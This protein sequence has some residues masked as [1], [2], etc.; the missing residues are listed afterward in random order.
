MTAG[1]PWQS[2]PRGFLRHLFDAALTAADPARAMARHP[3]PPPEGRM[4]VIGAGKAAAA[5]AQMVEDRWPAPH[6]GLVLVPTG[7]GLPCRRIEVIEAGHPLPDAAGM[8]AARRML[9]AASGLGGGD[10][11]L[12]LL[13]GGGSALL[14]LPAPGLTLADKREITDKLLRAGAAIGEINCVRKHLSAIKGG[15]LAAA[16]PARCFSLLISDVTGDDPATIAS[17]PGLADSTTLADARQVLARHGIDPPAAIARHLADAAAETPKPGDTRLAAAEA[18][19]TLRAADA[20]R[21]AADAA[22]AAGIDAV[23]LGDAAVGEARMLGEAQA[24]LAVARRGRPVVLLSGGEATVTVR[25]TDRGGPNGEFALALAL[26]LAGRPGIHALACDTDGIDGAS[27]AAGAIVGPDTLAR[28]AA[29]GL[30]PAGHLA[31][32]DSHGLFA[33]LGDLIVTGP[34]RTNVNDFRAILVNQN[35]ER[36]RQTIET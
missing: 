15:R 4:F 7:H 14:A 13:S 36:S 22:R 21:A 12:C 30:D 20:V 17:G 27:D 18:V 35:S 10:L 32:N 9:D 26:A 6:S 19:I 31:A 28:A 23:I 3:P 16:W 24:G 2:D 11:L 1:A 33:A 25:G 29:M 5:M 8:A 34:T